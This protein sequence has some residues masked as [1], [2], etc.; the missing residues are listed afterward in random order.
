MPA[1]E[2]ARHP[3]NPRRSNGIES[4]SIKDASRT[5]CTKWCRAARFRLTDPGSKAD[6]LE[7]AHRVLLY[8]GF[9]LAEEHDVPGRN[10][11]LRGGRAGRS[12]GGRRRRGAYGLGRPH[13]FVDLLEEEA[14]LVLAHP[15]VGQR[16]GLGEAQ[17]VDESEALAHVAEVALLLLAHLV[18][19][20]LVLLV[21]GVDALADLE[22]LLEAVLGDRAV[23]GRSEAVG[24]GLPVQRLDPALLARE[25][26]RLAL[27][28]VRQAAQ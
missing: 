5:G 7:P 16:L 26:L 10:V 20:F 8:V 14:V 4:S 27:R 2:T 11:G 22:E 17:L 19:L 23:G 18:Q 28:P 12:S 25:L 6:P 1:G 3:R 15:E 13:R 9:V 24:V 21:H